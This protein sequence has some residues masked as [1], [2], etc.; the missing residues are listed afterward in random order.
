LT[1][2][3]RKTANIAGL[4]SHNVVLCDIPPNPTPPIPGTPPPPPHSADVLVYNGNFSATVSA[5][6]R[7]RISQPVIYFYLLHRTHRGRTLLKIVII[8]ILQ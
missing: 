2:N 6:I 3:A 7:A 1:S 5:I 8:V 4:M